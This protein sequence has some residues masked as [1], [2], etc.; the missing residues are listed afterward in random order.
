MIRA[1][2]VGIHPMVV[3]IPP[4]RPAADELIGDPAPAVVEPGVMHGHDVGVVEPRHRP[5]LAEEPLHHPLARIGLLEHLDRHVA[6][7]PG[8]VGPEHLAEPAVTQPLAQ[9][10]SPQRAQRAP[11]P[12]LDPV[13]RLAGSVGASSATRRRCDSASSESVSLE[14]S[15]WLESAVDQTAAIRTLDSPPRLPQS[16]DS[17]PHS[18]DSLRRPRG[19]RDSSRPSPDQPLVERSVSS[20]R[21]LNIAYVI[22][23]RY[24][25]A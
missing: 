22:D 4:Q 15:T 23:Q 5:G 20:F 1:T 6:I 12:G 17:A 25:P 10:K 21:W 19:P 11:R 2:V 16:R 18:A 8:I 9:L 3:A 13:D 24:V 7:E 14:R